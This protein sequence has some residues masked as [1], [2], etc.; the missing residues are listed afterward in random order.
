VWKALWF[1]GPSGDTSFGVGVGTLVLATN[2]VLLGGYTLSCHSLRHLAGGARDEVSKSPLCLTA[3]G[4]V[5][6]LNRRHMAWAWASLFW[7]AFSDV[8]VR[9]L[10]MGVWSDARLL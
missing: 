7:V 1:D 4:C 10:S 9:L 8:Y 2:V 6:A 3:Y 5:S